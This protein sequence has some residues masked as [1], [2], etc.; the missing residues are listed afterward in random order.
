MRLAEPLSLN[1]AVT[2]RSL[3]RKSLYE[4]LSLYWF[5]KLSLPVSFT[6]PL[7]TSLTLPPSL[8]ASSI[9]TSFLPYALNPHFTDFLTSPKYHLPNFAFSTFPREIAITPLDWVKKTGDLKW[10]KG[11]LSR[12]FIAKESDELTCHISLN[13]G[14]RWRALRSFGEAPGARRACE[15]GDRSHVEAVAVDRSDSNTR[16]VSDF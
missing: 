9:G 8:L 5:S 13:R 10:Y 6:S 7:P 4:T 12:S 11:E 3:T 16:F 15:G 2:T 14:R 1:T